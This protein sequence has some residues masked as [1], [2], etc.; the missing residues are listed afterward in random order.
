MCHAF[1]SQS[2]LFSMKFSMWSPLEMMKME[3]RYT[4]TRWQYSTT[5]QEKSVYFLFTVKQSD[6]STIRILSIIV[7]NIIFNQKNMSKCAGIKKKRHEGTFHP[8]QSIMTMYDNCPISEKHLWEFIGGHGFFWTK[9]TSDREPIWGTLC[10]CRR[11]PVVEG[12]SGLFSEITSPP[13]QLEKA[14]IQ[15]PHS[16]CF[17]LWRRA[18]KCLIN[19]NGDCL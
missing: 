7:S 8:P 14:P 12:E 13:A 10:G 2:N 4:G 19:P 17:M 11:R 16:S 9:D 3:S 6:L 5:V 15:R 1:Q 18:L